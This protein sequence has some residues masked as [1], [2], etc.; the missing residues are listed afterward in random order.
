MDITTLAVV[1]LWK[2]LRISDWNVTVLTMLAA[3]GLSC[4]VIHVLKTEE[5]IPKYGI[6][7]FISKIIVVPNYSSKYFLKLIISKID[8]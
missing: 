5:R 7:N 2:L 3:C 4:P 8:M 6:L 1:V